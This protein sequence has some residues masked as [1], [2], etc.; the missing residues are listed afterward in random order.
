MPLFIDENDRRI[1]GEA[2]KEVLMHLQMDRCP[3][4]HRY[5]LIPGPR[6]GASQNLT[7][8]HCGS[9]WNV[10]PPRYIMFVQRLERGT[11][12]RKATS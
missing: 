4:C 12:Q 1:E 11:K 10:A 9:K 7:C 3:D 8:G 6:G 5:E 2:G